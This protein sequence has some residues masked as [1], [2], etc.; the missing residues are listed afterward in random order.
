MHHS[1][2]PREREEKATTVTTT[3]GSNAK[4]AT[5]TRAPENSEAHRQ[6]RKAAKELEEI[7]QVINELRTELSQFEVRREVLRQREAALREAVQQT[8]VKKVTSSDPVVFEMGMGDE[9]SPVTTPL[10]SSGPSSVTLEPAGAGGRDAGAAAGSGASGGA[11][12]G[13]GVGAGGGLG[14]GPA[15][16]EAARA[17]QGL[18]GEG[19]FEDWER[20]LESIGVAKCGVCGMKFPLDTAEIEKHC[21]ECEAAQKEGRRPTRHDI[22][23]ITGPG[24]SLPRSA[25]A[26][27]G[28]ASGKKPPPASS[29]AERPMVSAAA[30]L[31]A[32]VGAP[33]PLG[34]P[35]GQGVSAAPPPHDRAA[36]L[37]K[38]MAARS[39][40]ERPSARWGV[41]G[42]LM[43]RA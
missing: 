4:D 1:L 27:A 16:K 7:D 41:A 2:S 42:S 14:A 29:P 6:W 19:G 13:G 12:G 11:G 38:K 28:G 5:S 37:R 23:T 18:Q 34:L 32:A 40:S 43:G 36:K 9:D 15:A 20:G 39:K 33:M 26:G 17:A 22:V 3:P 21:L 35:Q 10:A 24:G 30:L 8:P 31:K 25:A